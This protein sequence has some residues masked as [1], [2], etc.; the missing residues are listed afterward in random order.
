MEGAPFEQRGRQLS[1]PACILACLFW[2]T[3]T[4]GYTELCPHEVSLQLTRQSIAFCG[5]G[6]DLADG[7]RR[8][9]H[10]HPAGHASGGRSF[11]GS[12][13]GDR[14][15]P[16]RNPHITA[17]APPSSSTGLGSM[18]IARLLAKVIKWIGQINRLY[19]DNGRARSHTHTHSHPW[20][21]PLPVI[22]RIKDALLHALHT[23]ALQVAAHDAEVLA[24][25]QE[26][27]EALKAQK[28]GREAQAFTSHFGNWY[29]RRDRHQSRRKCLK[30]IPRWAHSKTQTPF[31]SLLS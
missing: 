26:R 22:N 25:R 27:D 12:Q 16:N 30:P 10:A 23:C 3:H 4:L 2:S 13:A 24:L 18:A 9:E 1:L 28:S 21:E 15:A 14:P 17:Y 7:A 5:A 19:H 6:A 20:T 31:L 8:Q 29:L 11:Q